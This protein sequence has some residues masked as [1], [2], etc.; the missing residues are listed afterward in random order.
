MV[1]YHS[2]S[3]YHLPSEFNHFFT[4]VGG[5]K[6]ADNL[7][8][9]VNMGNKSSHILVGSHDLPPS[10]SP[11][12][13]SLSRKLHLPTVGHIFYDISTSGKRIIAVSSGY[14][15]KSLILNPRETKRVGYYFEWL[16]VQHLK[17]LGITHI[18]TTQTPEPPRVRQ[19]S[20]IGLPIR[21]EV[22]IGD[23]LAGL[24]HGWK[25]ETPARARYILNKIRNSILQT[26][27]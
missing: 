21:K 6:D 12:N 25:G 15:P 8:S 16:A 3:L 7:P 26:D 24:E 13:A 17:T 23:W 14:Y 11:F 2:V 18:S 20:K 1:E 9:S 5:D 4:F 22:P 10:V 27:I 19:L